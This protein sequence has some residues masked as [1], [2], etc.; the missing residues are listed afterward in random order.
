MRIVDRQNQLV[1]EGEIGELQLK[2][3]TVTS[4]YYQNLEANQQAFTKDGWF[5][6]RDLE[7]LKNGRLAFTGNQ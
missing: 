4:G 5:N 1:Q 2:G 6:T 3:L 7:F